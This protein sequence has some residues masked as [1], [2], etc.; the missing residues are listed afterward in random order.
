MEAIA[1][2]KGKN[3]STLIRICP[4]YGCPILDTVSSWQ[5]GVPAS[6]AGGVERGV[7]FV[8]ANDRSP[9]WVLQSSVAPGYNSLLPT[10][11][12]KLLSALNTGRS[13]PSAPH[14]L[15]GK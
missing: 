1:V 6:F 8:V 9:P 4:P 12:A 3:Y 10:F 7:S 15:S 14:T 2:L 13:T 5:A 11:G